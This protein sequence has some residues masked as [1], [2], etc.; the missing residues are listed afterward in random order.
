M[1]TGPQEQPAGG[2]SMAGVVPCV[3]P[4]C[5]HWVLA[6]PWRRVPLRSG[7]PRVP[8][9]ERS[10]GPLWAPLGLEGCGEAMGIRCSPGV[11]DSALPV[12][13]P[14]TCLHCQA[15]HLPLL[16]EGF[17]GPSLFHLG[18]RSTPA[19]PGPVPCAPLP[20]KP[21]A[22]PEASCL[23]SRPTCLSSR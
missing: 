20:S 19:T 18:I 4:E 12:L 11:G 1:S 10:S 22:Q 8:I 2:C 15:P 3:L 6:E 5:H 9:P 14:F 16:R 17:P 13:P 7:G 23:C 21:T